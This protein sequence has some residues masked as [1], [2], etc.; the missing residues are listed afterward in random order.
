MNKI[1]YYYLKK[2]T[3]GKSTTSY[4]IKRNN[5]YTLIALLQIH[6]NFLV[7]SSKTIKVT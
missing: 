6:D 4:L 1:T 5:C 7:I 3:R 2:I